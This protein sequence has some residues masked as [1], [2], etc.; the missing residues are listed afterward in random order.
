MRTKLYF[1]ITLLAFFA[2]AALPNSFAQL[3]VPLADVPFDTTNIPEPVPPPAAVRDFFQLDPYYQQWIN[4]RGFP[5]LASAEVRPY[6]VKEVAWTIGQMIG[7]RPDILRAMAQ[8]RARFAI[9]PHNKHLPEIP[10]Y[11]F[12]RLDFFWEMRARGVGGRITSSPEENIICGDRN[13]C[14][15]EV[16]HEFAHQVHDYGLG[17][18]GIQ[19]VDPTFDKRLETLYNMAKGEGLYQNRYAGSNRMEY[20]AEGVGS[21]FNGPHPANVAHTR[22]ALKEYDPH[23][24]NLLTEVFGDDDWRYTPPATRIH[25][26]HLQGFDPQEAPR[27][28]RPARLLK[29]ETQLRDPDSDGDGK[30]VNLKLHDPSELPRLLNSAGKNNNSTDFLFVNLTRTDLSLY[31]FHVEGKKSLYQHSTTNDVLH[32]PTWVGAIWLIQDHT[33]KDL[34]VFRAEEQVGRVLIGGPPSQEVLDVNSDGIVDLLDLTPIASRYGH[35]GEN[36]ADINIDRIVNI[37]DVLLV[38]GS[39]AALPRQVVETFKAT[40]VQKWLTDAKQL[41]IADEYQQKGIV[42]LEHLLAEIAF[43]STPKE[44]AGQSETV[45]HGH[46]DIVWSVAFSPDGQTLASSGW[47]NKIR[48]W[49]AETKQHEI[50]LIERAE[51]MTV[52]FSPNGQTLV[53]GNWDAAVRLWDPSTGEIKKTL[54]GHSD[55]IESIVFSPDGAT[56]ASGSADGTIRLWDTSTGTLKRTLTGQGRMRSVA[57]SPDGATLAS[58]SSD[59]TI[60]LWN[61]DTG[62]LK[63]TLTGHTDWVEGLAFS[64][65]GNTLASGG[66]GTRDRTLRLWNPHNGQEIRKFTGYTGQVSGIA[67]SPDGRLLASG[68]WGPKI[69]LWNTETGKDENALAGHTRGVISVAFSPD[70]RLLVSGG[71]DGTVRLW[72]VSTL[73]EPRRDSD[74]NGDGVVN[75]LDLVLVASNFGQTGE[76]IADV[77]GDGI[78]NI[79]DLVLVAGEMGTGADAPSVHLSTLDIL[80]AA[81]VQNWLTQA[82]HLDLTDATSQRGILRLQQLLAALIPKQTAL[83][84]NYPNPFNPE[85]WIPYHLAKPADVKVRIYA[86]DGALVRTLALGYQVA[87]IYERRNRAAYWDGK[88][89]V[90]EKVASGIYFYTLF[91]NDF[92]ATRKMLILK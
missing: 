86:A 83:L 31:F 75:I 88:N 5:V 63:R 21:W 24:A 51:I 55:G 37:V 32:V 71:E 4:I 25:L 80:T 23:L 1:V 2:L 57:F 47:D 81:D 34:A 62:E 19:G 50:T 92:T 40:E 56:L 82:Q 64:P 42:V 49:N 65:D 78:V 79:V 3:E 36:P 84:P 12:G 44:A 48:L 52:A 20:W 13:Y 45:F 59:H 10:E 29:L 43:L 26:P 61:P 91:A 6:T 74:V 27:Y 70:G 46:T 87:G 9:V 17:N 58:G 53:S 67:F 90:G 77:N 41:D 89:E 11:D 28:Q 8:N 76:N 38:A 68:S 72:D 22:S 73:L 30:W 33:G 16:I 14:Y 60:Q 54:I 18:W 39:V 69:R 35:R 15:A 85:T 7:H 66:G